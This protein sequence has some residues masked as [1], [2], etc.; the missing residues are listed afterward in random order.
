MKKSELKNII[1]EVLLNEKY[2]DD[3]DE[4]AMALTYALENLEDTLKKVRNPEGW[5]E[6]YMRS[7]PGVID[8]IEKLTNILSRMK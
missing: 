5:A 1:S 4:A 8:H 2:Y 3:P 6:K 7:V